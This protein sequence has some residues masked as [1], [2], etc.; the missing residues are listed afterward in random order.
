MIHLDLNKLERE[1]P[2]FLN[3]ADVATIVS[4]LDD[5][6][7][8]IIHDNDGNEIS[9]Q[10]DDGYDW[11]AKVSAGGKTIMVVGENAEDLANGIRA[12]AA[13][14]LGKEVPPDIQQ[15]MEDDLQKGLEELQRKFGK[16]INIDDLLASIDGKPKKK[17]KKNKK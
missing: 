7:E 2:P 5:G 12:C 17:K 6:Q 10:R 13:Q 4:Q 1:A 16:L 9:V 3:K 11:G 14:C 15:N 8:H